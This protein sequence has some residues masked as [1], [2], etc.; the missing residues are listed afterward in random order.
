LSSL[1]EVS[2]VQ[3]EDHWLCFVLQ[4]SGLCCSHCMPWS[5]PTAPWALHCQPSQSF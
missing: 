3:V 4:G 1:Y 2:P 5:P